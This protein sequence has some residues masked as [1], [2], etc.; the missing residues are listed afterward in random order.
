MTGQ[1]WF[2]VDENMTNDS[3][4]I[5]RAAATSEDLVLFDKIERE[6]YTAVV[7]DALDELGYRDQA[8]SHSIRPLSPNVSL[9]GWA[10]TI[11]CIDVNEIPDEPYATE[12]EAIDSILTGEV[13]V[14]STGG[15]I[16]NA[17]WG[18]LLSTAAMARGARG[19]IV[20]GLVRDVKKIEKLGFSV[21]ARGIKPVDSKGRGIV[22]DYNVPVSCGG[23]TVFPGDLVVGDYDGLV[24]VPAVI[25]QEVLERANRKVTSENHSREELLRGAYLRDVYEKYGVL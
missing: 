9:A 19:A 3:H 5:I 25:A 6:L 20:D 4:R 14:I 2:R 17:P 21:F 16:R 13:A 18:E 7:S 24:V 22:I 12:I 1:E 10:R 15:S 11:M 23:V 8:M